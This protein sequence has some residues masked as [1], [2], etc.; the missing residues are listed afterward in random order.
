MH[1][2]PETHAERTGT[3]GK[4]YTGASFRPPYSLGTPAMHG[5]LEIADD[6]EGCRRDPQRHPIDQFEGPVR[7]LA[8]FAELDFTAPAPQFGKGLTLP[9]LL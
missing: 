8:E 7:E 3:T 1:R 9:I 4:K 2:H 5:I 6:G